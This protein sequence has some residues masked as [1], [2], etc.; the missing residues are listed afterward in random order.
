MRH[1]NGWSL[2]D[3][4][5]KSGAPQTRAEV[6]A[7]IARSQPST[8]L[9]FLSRWLELEDEH[10]QL[11]TQAGHVR[12]TLGDKVLGNLLHDRTVDITFTMVRRARELISKP[13]R[14]AADIGAKV[15]VLTRIDQLSDDEE[16]KSQMCKSIRQDV[17]DLDIDVER[18]ARA[19]QS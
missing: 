18:L 12:D 16:L 13:S 7:M 3:K 4:A 19:R 15:Y 6:D 10:A 14:Q 8:V 17:E 2:R 1:Q 9:T 5:A 11:E